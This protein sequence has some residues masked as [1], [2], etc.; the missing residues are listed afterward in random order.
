MNPITSKKNTE[1]HRALPLILLILLGFVWGTGYS[2][3]RFAVTNGVNPLGYSFWQSLGPA[4]LICLITW[5]GREK[6]KIS[7][8]HCRY[9]FICGLTGIAL[10]NTNMYFAAPHL[11]AGLLAVIVNT[12]PI[13]AYIMALIARVESFSWIRLTAVGL[14]LSGLMLILLPVSSLPSPQMIPWIL[15]ALL[16]PLCF[17]FCSVYITR[18]R[19][20][21]STSLS[22]AAGT[23][24]F[25]SIFLTPLVLG[26]HSF[27]S[28]HMP[29]TMPDW[30]ILLE[31]LL[32]S[33]GYVL[34]FK[35]LQ[36]SGPVYYSF[37][38]TIV[39]ITGLFWGHLIF[40]EQL[41]FWTS[42][43][44]VL[45]LL[46]LILV[47]KRQKAMLEYGSAKTRD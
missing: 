44:V 46:S 1:V 18:Y 7:T 14:A 32:S 24:V 38:D 16:T 5:S 22:L 37:V 25:S 2:I 3:A 9:Y 31:I 23:L 26:T 34:F 15:S 21:D 10:P 19:P 12:V 27:Y 33:I 39:A 11:P 45:I 29:L 43:A 36:I 6:I 40:G 35:L 17:A 20:A 42:I 47:N 41:N 4:I 28:F 13:M 30:V 8:S